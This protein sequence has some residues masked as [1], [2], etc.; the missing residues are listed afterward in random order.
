V[1]VDAKGDLPNIPNGYNVAT[2][3]QGTVYYPSGVELV[4]GEEGRNGV[5]FEG[6]KG[7]LFVNR[8]TIAGV[9][10]DQ[11]KDDPLPREQFHLYGFDNHDRPERVGKLDAIVNHMG[12]FFDCVRARREPISD[13]V[14]QH[15]SAATCHL[16]NISMR[17]GRP[18]QWDGR[19][20][21]IIDDSEANS[22][23]RRE[24]RRGFEVV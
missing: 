2:H 10:F 23:L 18:I 21:T 6:E 24:Q 11:L 20:E 9:P 12:N 22:M 8:G 4:V 19:A 15:R 1:A 3:F 7:R 17:V 14:S 13:C 5:L 16:V